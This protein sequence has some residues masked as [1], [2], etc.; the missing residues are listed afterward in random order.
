[1]GISPSLRRCPSYGEARGAHPGHGALSRGE[2]VGQGVFA[3]NLH[4]LSNRSDKPSLRSTVRRFP[5]SSIES[6]LFRRRARGAFIGACRAGQ[7]AFERADGGTCSSTRSARSSAIA[8]GKL[9]RVLQEGEAE[10]LVTPA[11]AQVDVG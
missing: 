10:R 11:P 3:R 1:M 8:Q 7:A 4:R 2:R 5:S 6:E 9:L